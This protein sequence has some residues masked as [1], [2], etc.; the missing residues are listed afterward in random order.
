MSNIKDLEIVIQA[1]SQR[2]AELEKEIALHADAFQQEKKVLW[3]ATFADELASYPEVTLAVGYNNVYFSVGNKEIGAI[4]R[5]GWGGYK[6]D[7][8]YFNTYSTFIEDE[9]E[10]KRLIFNGK[11]AEK[12]LYNQEV[13]SHLLSIKYS[14]AEEVEELQK[15]VYAFDK[16]INQK[17]LEIIE[18]KKQEVLTKLHGEGMDYNPNQRFE[19][20]NRWSNFHVKKVRIANFTKSG[21][22]VD[23]EV[24][25]QIIDWSYDEEGNE[26]K[27]E[28]EDRVTLHEKV[29]MEYV[30]NNFRDYI[31]N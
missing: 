7:E 8:F 14:K 16:E 19:L 22:T 5:R 18:E 29:K 9:F 11:V 24:T 15:Q 1:L 27:T 4:C 30:W 6:E 28:R 26:K 10:Y 12:I 23:L 3:E 20:A 17:S 25:Y 21:K 2:K 31:Y 13:I